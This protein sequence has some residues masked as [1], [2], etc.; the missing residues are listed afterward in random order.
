MMQK[1]RGA[2]CHKARGHAAAFIEDS[3]H[4]VYAA[5]TFWFGQG[6]CRLG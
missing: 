5:V 2:S 1:L 4:H 6:G 3:A